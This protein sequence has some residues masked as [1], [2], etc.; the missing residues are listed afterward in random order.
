MSINRRHLAQALAGFGLGA[1]L[2]STWA[3]QDFPA[4]NI[5]LVV[6][7]PPGGANDITAR[8]VAQ[9]LGEVL[10]VSVAV[11]NRAGA[12]GLIGSDLVAKSAPDGYTLL[13]GGL[14]PMVLN[15][16][17]YPKLPYGENDLVG[18]ST[19]ASSPIVFAV[20]P[21]LPV[22]NLQE[23]IR[24]AKSKPD[25]VRF[26]TVGS[27]GSTRVVLELLNQATGADI[28][29]IPYKGAA[30]GIT[31]ILAGNVDGMGVDLPALLPFIKD[32]RL[33]GI[34]ITSEARNSLL[35]D[36]RTAAEQGVPELT[37]GNW[38]AAVAPSRTPR[39][40]LQRLHA[41]LQQVVAMP[42][43]RQQTI[44]GGA[45]PRASASPEA[46]ASFQQAELARWGKVI[47][48]AGIEAE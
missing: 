10:K 29:Y 31:D 33:R 28:K 42:E 37:C 11:Y 30:P 44:N 5:R 12:N 3:Q 20:R 45:E 32:G 38:Y 26:A 25:A 16:L 6:G 43:F 7:Y 34:A 35:P 1:A 48:T 15:R 23:L 27:G 46:F 41:A 8:M 22:T 39:P 21:S 36:L 17:T 9:R 13:M 40:I 2:P 19:V 14:T 24:L 18:V 47:K 4:R